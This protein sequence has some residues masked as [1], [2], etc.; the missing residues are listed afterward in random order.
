[1]EYETRDF[2]KVE[3]LPER[4]IE[5]VG[6][7][8]GYENYTKYTFLHDQQLGT[9]IVWMQ[10]LEEKNLCFLLADPTLVPGYAPQIP[11]QA[12]E[13]LGEGEY[14]C[15]PIMV[16]PND[17]KNATVNL[18]SPIVVNTTQRK[19]MQLVL[20]EDYPIRTPLFKGE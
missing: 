10:S 4:V 2:G 13:K 20:A 1:M 12:V 19:A 11:E 18:K 7:V 5:F 17:W 3:I 6:P 16:V 8:L 14:L 9:S 15:L